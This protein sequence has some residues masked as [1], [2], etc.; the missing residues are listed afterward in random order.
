MT[1]NFEELE[2]EAEFEYVL[3]FAKPL[4]LLLGWV[5]HEGIVS[6]LKSSG[7]QYKKKILASHSE[8]WEAA[9]KLFDY[10]KISA[11]VGKITPDIL[12]LIVH[13]DYLSARDCLFRAVGS[14][15]NQIY[16]FEDVFVGEQTDRFRE[17]YSPYPERQ[18]MEQAIEFL[19]SCGVELVPY[20]RRADVTVL[21]EAFL[22]DVDRNLIFR[23]YVP[24]GR[25]WSGEADTFLQLF[26]DYLAK[27]DQLRVRLDQKRT[28]HGTIYEFHGQPPE[29]QNNLVQEFNE[30]S[31]LM[32]LCAS[33][34]DAAAGLL[35]S[36]KL[37][38]RET[39]RLLTRYSKEAKRLQ[40][41]I[42]HEA[43]SKIIAIRQRLE[44]EFIDLDPSPEDWRAIEA[45][46]NLAI[47][48]VKGVLPMPAQSLGGIPPASAQGS[49]NIIYNFKPQFIGTVNGVIAD[50][51]HGNQ[52]FV[53]EQRQLLELVSQHG[54]SQQR[55]LETA[56]YEVADKG[57]DKVD[58]LK[59]K[60]RLTA[61]LIA[62]GKKTGDVAVGL[63]QKYIENQL[64]L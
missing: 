45:L 50:E 24:S 43:E 46:V 1:N 47:P 5:D 40:L 39:T 9:A 49:A 22:N 20:K 21:A 33:D 35:A 58:R 32:N 55:E 44:S 60:Q 54:G 64:G 16:I 36:K 59:A 51:I 28:D 14:V 4:V 8:N 18:V 37:D 23:L 61:F 25:L 53:E 41:D 2:P 52:H 12:N 17:E 38:P 27:V 30:F 26:Q 10:F 63:I 3:D 6:A 19:R 13:E 31:Q 34:T 15:P 11:V 42:K 29:G 62:V 7:R 48:V 57:V 56:V